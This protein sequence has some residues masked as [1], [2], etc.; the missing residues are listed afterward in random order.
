MSY[1]F[2]PAPFTPLPKTP[3]EL[4][5]ESLKQKDKEERRKQIL[6]SLGEIEELKSDIL[7]MSS[8]F[9]SKQQNVVYEFDNYLNSLLRPSADV[10]EHIR[11]LNN[12]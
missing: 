11:K 10:E 8:Y 12:L 5:Q 1:N 6:N 9:Y 7:G 2:S 3:S 4:H